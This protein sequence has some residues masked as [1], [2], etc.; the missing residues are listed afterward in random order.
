MAGGGA[1]C[2]AGFDA[3]AA[4]CSS[5][6]RTG[7]APSSCAS[8]ARWLTLSLR[9]R[10]RRGG[11]KL[12]LEESRGVGQLHCPPVHTPYSPQTVGKEQKLSGNILI[13]SDT[14]VHALDH[15]YSL[16]CPS[17]SNLMYWVD[18]ASGSE[19]LASGLLSCTDCT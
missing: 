19:I 11:A 10:C 14:M 2:P 5:L 17:D 12:H 6:G 9:S 4:A 13:T 7:S 8:P 16:R 15:S 1:S 18:V 3:G